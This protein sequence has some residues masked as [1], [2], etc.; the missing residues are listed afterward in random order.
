MYINVAAS[1]LFRTWQ[2]FTRSGD[3]AE[4]GSPA[5][6]SPPPSHRGY[7]TVL[8][9]FAPHPRRISAGNKNLTPKWIGP[10]PRGNALTRPRKENLCPAWLPPYK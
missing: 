6:I 9:H 4:S 1:R 10:I 8:I 5:E 3:L 2:Q 7:K